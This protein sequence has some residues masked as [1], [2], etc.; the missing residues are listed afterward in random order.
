MQFTTAKSTMFW[1]SVNVP[2][3]EDDLEPF[4]SGGSSLGGSGGGGGGCKRK[5]TFEK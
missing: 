3:L 2:F 5:N 4:S 1:P